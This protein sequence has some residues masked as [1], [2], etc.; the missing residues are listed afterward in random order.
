MNPPTIHKLKTMKKSRNNS[1][2]K[3]IGVIHQNSDFDVIEEESADKRQK[4]MY[5]DGSTGA[6]KIKQNKQEQLE[7]V[8][9]D[10]LS[11]EIGADFRKS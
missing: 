7:A 6:S 11:R 8:E 10:S 2:Q 5:L 4:K 1:S 3:N 9:S